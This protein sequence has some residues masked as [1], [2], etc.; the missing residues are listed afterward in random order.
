MIVFG[1]GLVEALDERLLQPIRQ[2]APQWYIKMTDAEKV[3]IVA[4]KL[5]DYAG[6]L[7]AATIARQRMS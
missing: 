7:G 5:G 1:G 3:R 2:A 4:A 6:V